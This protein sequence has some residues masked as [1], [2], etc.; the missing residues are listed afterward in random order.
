MKVKRESHVKM[1][2]IDQITVVNARGRGRSKFKQIVAN[3]SHIG[4]KKPITVARR[5]E[6]DGLMVPRW[7]QG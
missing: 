2:P 5:L 3:I 4:L 6:N 7:H 1:I